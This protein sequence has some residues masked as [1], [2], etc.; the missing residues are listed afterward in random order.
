MSWCRMK[1]DE[2]QGAS[3]EQTES[4][5]AYYEGA[6]ELAT[7][8]IAIFIQAPIGRCRDDGFLKIP[9]L[10]ECVCYVTGRALQ[11]VLLLL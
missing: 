3:E 1:I 6:P 10:H 9:T 11:R 2:M 7:K 5:R 8:Q 4:Y